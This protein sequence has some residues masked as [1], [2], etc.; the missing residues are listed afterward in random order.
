M[1]Y[2]FL[3]SKLFVAVN[4]C[5]KKTLYLMKRKV[6]IYSSILSISTITCIFYNSIESIGV[7]YMILYWNNM[8]LLLNVT[9]TM[10]QRVMQIADYS[11]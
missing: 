3:H 1:L 10:S 9:A 5:N 4:Q 8:L 7:R 2:N 6:L 11:K